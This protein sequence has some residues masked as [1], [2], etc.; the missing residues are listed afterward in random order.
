M[1][2]KRIKVAFGAAFLIGVGSVVAW[3]VTNKSWRP[4]RSYLCDLKFSQGVYTLD[5]PTSRL[6]QSP[7]PSE[8]LNA[9]VTVAHAV[10]Y[11]VGTTLHVS[12]NGDGSIL[13]P[14]LAGRMLVS[15]PGWGGDVN[16]VRIGVTIDRP[17]L[18]SGEPL[19]AQVTIENHGKSP[20]ELRYG[21][22]ANLD[23]ALPEIDDASGHAVRKLFRIGQDMCFA[24]FLVTIPVKTTAYFIF[25]VR[26]LYV[27]DRPGKYTMS[28]GFPTNVYGPP[29]PI[30]LLHS[31][32]VAFEVR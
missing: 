3:G 16:G 7:D 12:Q 23:L 6:G 26:D 14:Y 4:W 19:Y 10:H 20:F 24:T 1:D 30:M 15:D 11:V 25:N 2:M 5:T 31:G 21:C 8:K 29:R 17:V 28:I 9:K 32:R 18:K 22:G 27:I 13:V